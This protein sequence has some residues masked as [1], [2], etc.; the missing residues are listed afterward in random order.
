MQ[1]YGSSIG[2]GDCC[3]YAACR[4][5]ARQNSAKRKSEGQAAVLSRDD[6]IQGRKRGIFGNGSN[7]AEGEGA[8]FRAAVSDRSTQHSSL[9]GI[10]REKQ[11]DGGSEF[12]SIVGR[13]RRYTTG[14]A[15]GSDQRSD[16]EK[17]ADSARD[18]DYNGP[19][20]GNLLK[21]PRKR[22]L[23]IRSG[24]GVSGYEGERRGE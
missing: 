7:Q 23:G 11:C 8:R 12:R 10:T 24:G 17:R 20:C 14:V 13:M 18:S 21:S 5:P 2:I 4:D 16:E 3:L 15:A 9:M 19:G 1:V 22:R 6:W